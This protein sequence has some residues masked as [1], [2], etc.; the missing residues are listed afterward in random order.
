MCNW[1]SMDLTKRSVKN[2]IMKKISKS[3]IEKIQKIEPNTIIG[4]RLR[5]GVKI[6]Y[7]K[8]DHLINHND[9]SEYTGYF[10]VEDTSELG[11]LWCKFCNPTK[12]SS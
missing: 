10:L 1:E 4:K 6:H 8:C 3:D 9:R 7:A 12:S 5:H 11:E 2:N